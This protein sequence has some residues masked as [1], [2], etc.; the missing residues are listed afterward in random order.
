M[1]LT[2]REGEWLDLEEMAAIGECSDFKWT[3]GEFVCGN[4][5]FD[6]GVFVV[7][8]VEK[9]IDLVEGVVSLWL[10]NTISEL[11]SIEEE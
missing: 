9:L 8:D 7:D 11:E 1:D 2:V 5:I 3:E 10:S 6:I 4:L